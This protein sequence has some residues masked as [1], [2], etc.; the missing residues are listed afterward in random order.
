MTR[1]STEGR[2][3][4]QREKCYVHVC[5][6]IVYVSAVLQHILVAIQM[7]DCAGMVPAGLVDD[8]QKFACSI[9]TLSQRD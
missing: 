2:V 8:W 7:H 4:S 6:C 1:S 3:A 9:E 5:M